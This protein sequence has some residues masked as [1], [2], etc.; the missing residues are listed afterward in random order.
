MAGIKNGD[1]VGIKYVG[2]LDD[3]SV[4]DKNEEGKPLEFVMGKNEI[5]IGLEKGLL[6]MKKGEKKKIKVKQEEAYGKYDGSLVQKIPLSTVPGGRKIEKDMMLM[7]GDNRGGRRLVRVIE[8]EK[9]TFTLDLNHPFAGKD[10]TFEV[11]IVSIN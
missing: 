1:K 7:V 8:V 11:E 10:L 6:R 3:G 4:F 5:I 2:K 9:D